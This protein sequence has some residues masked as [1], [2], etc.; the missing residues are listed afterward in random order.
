L[1][2]GELKPFFSPKTK[3]VDYQFA[4]YD[5]WGSIVFS[6]KD[7]AEGWKGDKN[8]A[9]C[10][11]GVYVWRLKVRYQAAKQQEKTSQQAG[12]VLLLR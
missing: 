8:G 6:S 12:E 2:N 1:V 11:Q 7:P 4:I 5:R 3:V 9:Q 10:S